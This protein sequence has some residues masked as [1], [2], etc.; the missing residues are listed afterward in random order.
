MSRA[1]PGAE[2]GAEPV[3]A[4][5]GEVFLTGGTGFVGGAVL[6]HLLGEGRRVRAL[7][8]TD[9]QAQRLRELGAEPWRGDILDLEGL[10]ALIRGAAVVYHLAG[11]NELCPK[12]PRALY[13]ANVDGSGNVIVAAARTGVRRVVHTSSSTTIGEPA[14]A[15]PRSAYHAR[16]RRIVS[17]IGV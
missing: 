5:G 16:L 6:R 14:G 8:R 13:R 1:Q 3:P 10:T 2:P 15:M 9:E 12:D 7:C 11:G 4:A 17:S